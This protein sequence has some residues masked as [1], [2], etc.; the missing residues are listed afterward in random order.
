MGIMKSAGPMLMPSLLQLSLLNID[1]NNCTFWKVQHLDIDTLKK[2][3]LLFF[4][5]LAN[6]G[7]F[8]HNINQV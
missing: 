3:P 8:W 4:Q 1:V 7:Y 5:S 2:K 6:L